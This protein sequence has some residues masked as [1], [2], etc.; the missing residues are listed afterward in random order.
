MALLACS[1][2]APRP[3]PSAGDVSV[4]LIDRQPLFAAAISRL[5]SAS[6]PQSR[7]TTVLRAEQ[8]LELLA[9]TSP[10]LILC[11]ASGEPMSGVEFTQAIQEAGIDV[12]I[13]LLG[14]PSDED[15]LIE[16]LRVGC[17]GVFE[18]GCTER[19][20]IE[21]I[22]A[23]LAGYRVIYDKL[24]TRLLSDSSD[25]PTAPSNS[26][27]AQLST[28]ELAILSRIGEAKSVAAIA[29]ERGVSEKTIR[30]HLANI[31]RKLRLRNR[32]EAML[33]ATRLGL[34]DAPGGPVGPP[35]SA[36]KLI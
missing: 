25:Q 16:G 23:V 9:T 35:Y 36:V 1:I 22:T 32:T 20:F 2:T 27:A 15:L 34:T 5:L 26:V 30:N 13:A 18:K 14:E 10:N 6:F 3:I 4:F 7:I 28:T 8:A 19:E 31:Y 11:E 17:R 12:P 33:L 21:G 24:V 29:V